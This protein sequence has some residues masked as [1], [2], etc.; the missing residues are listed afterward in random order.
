MKVRIN[1]VVDVDDHFRTAVNKHYGR[2][3]LATPEDIKSWFRS[4]GDSMNDDMCY[5]EDPT[6][7][8]QERGCC[9]NFS[10]TQSNGG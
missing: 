7:L 1:Y 9:E 6:D 5:L 4:F 8:S 2:P 10:G 3:G